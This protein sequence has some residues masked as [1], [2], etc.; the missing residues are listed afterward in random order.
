MYH[1]QL[2]SEHLGD[3]ELVHDMMN[4]LTVAHLTTNSLELNLP[5]SQTL[6]VCKEKISHIKEN[7]NDCIS[8]AKSYFGIYKDTECNIGQEITRVLSMFNTVCIEKN[9]DVR[10]KS[11]VSLLIFG[12]SINF[13][14]VICNIFKNAI[15]ACEESGVKII[16]ICTK[17]TEHFVI[18][19]VRDSGIGL[20]K[21]YTKRLFNSSHS[22]KSGHGI[23]FQSAK[24]IV[25]NEFKGSITIVN[26]RSGIGATCTI[27]LPKQTTP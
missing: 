13:R 7:L 16:E 26:N 24:Q 1:E 6:N 2:D 21:I 11:H 17:E 23:G 19:N 14:R 3:T 22:T 15:E 8:I 9:I 12:R 10:Y 4:Y 27:T 20:P 25:E 5:K 18:I